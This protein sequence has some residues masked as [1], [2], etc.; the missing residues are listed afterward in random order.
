[1]TKYEGSLWKE[2]YPALHN[3]YNTSLPG[4]WERSFLLTSNTMEMNTQYFSKSNGSDFSTISFS[5]KVML[6]VC[7]VTLA[8]G[9]MAFYSLNSDIR[10]DKNAL[11]NKA[12]DKAVQIYV[13]QHGVF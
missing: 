10:E 5:F 7:L 4:Y 2:N 8:F 3:F 1:M 9:T 6:F 11:E 12:T 13:E